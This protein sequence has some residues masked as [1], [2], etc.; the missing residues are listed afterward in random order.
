MRGFLPCRRP[1]E[2]FLMSF[3]QLVPSASWRPASSSPDMWVFC[4]E[5]LSD[6]RFYK[7][8][9]VNFGQMKNSNVFTEKIHLFLW[10]SFTQCFRKVV[11]HWSWQ[12]CVSWNRRGG[13][14]QKRRET[15]PTAFPFSEDVIGASFPLLFCR[16]LENL[17]QIIKMAASGSRSGFWLPS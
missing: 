16:L 7:T 10:I 9:L 12:L 11:F 2:R 4:R 8:F 1:Q 15:N 14:P 5:P 3:G 6:W 13:G 17:D